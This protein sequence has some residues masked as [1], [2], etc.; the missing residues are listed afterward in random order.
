MNRLL[1]MKYMTWRAVTTKMGPNDASHVVWAH[2]E[3]FFFK[4]MFFLM[5]TNIFYLSIYNVHD[6]TGDDNEK[7]P[8]DARHV[9]WALG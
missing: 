2:G 9:V 1:C 5:L 3:S 8:N 6:R 7:G 4:I